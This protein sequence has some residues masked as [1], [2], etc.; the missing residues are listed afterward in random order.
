MKQ[1]ASQ[2]STS[3]ATDLHVCPLFMSYFYYLG[4]GT[5][6]FVKFATQGC[7]FRRLSDV[8]TTHMLEILGCL[9]DDCKGYFS[10]K[11][12]GRSWKNF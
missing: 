11:V 7:C 12:I 2:R 5:Y 1:D 6:I 10:G 3:V 4:E 8:R 9:M